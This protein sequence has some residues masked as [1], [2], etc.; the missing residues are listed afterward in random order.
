M[1]NLFQWMQT[2]EASQI[3]KSAQGKAWGP[4]LAKYPH[5]NKSKFE[6][7]VDFT[8]DH[9]ATA[10]VMYKAGPDYLKGVF[11][12]DSKYWPQAIKRALGLNAAGHGAGFPPQLSAF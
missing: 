7:T 6:A 11:G 4:F 8:L 12:S 9:K 5:A 1:A 2:S 3:A 10:E